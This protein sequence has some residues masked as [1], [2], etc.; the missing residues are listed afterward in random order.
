MPIERAANADF[1]ST[2]AHC[3]CGK[4]ICTMQ[5]RRCVAR[6][7]NDRKRICHLPIFASK[8]DTASG[9]TPAF[10]KRTKVS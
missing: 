10:T 7:G 1:G 4:R 2:Y 6:M 3:A 8:L 9:L 5:T